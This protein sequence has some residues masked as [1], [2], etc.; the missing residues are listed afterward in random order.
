MIVEQ[1]SEILELPEYQRLIEVGADRGTLAFG[2][3]VDAL[4]IGR[5]HV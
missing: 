2:E 5:A 1:P 3:I 4:E